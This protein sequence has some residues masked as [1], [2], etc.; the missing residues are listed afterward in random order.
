M[1]NPD[2]IFS[3]V[4][5]VDFASYI[6]GPAATTILSDFGATVIKVE[7]PGTG[8]PYRNLY[9]LAPNPVCDTNYPWQLTNRNKQSLA[10]DLKSPAAKDIVEKLVKWADVVVVN[11]PLSVRDKLGISYEALAPLND[12]LIY[13]DITGYGLKGPEANRPGFDV[14]TYWARSGLMEVTRDGDSPPAVPIPGIG[15]HATASTLFSAIVT[16]LYHREKTGKGSRVSTS[17]IAEGAWASALWTEGALNGAKFYGAHTRNA[18]LNALFNPYR[19][20]DNR[21]LLLMLLQANKEF[22]GL[23]KA[24][25]LPSLL[26]DPRFADSEGRT[27]HATELVG[28]LDKA[29]AGHSLEYWKKT[30]DEARVIYGVVQVADEVVKDEQMYANE[31]FVPLGEAGEK[32]TYTV[33]SPMQISGVDKVKPR[34]APDLGEHSRDVLATLGYDANEIERLINDKVVAQLDQAAQSK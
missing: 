32:T 21:W 30:F 2:S 25:D 23:C 26:E 18:P 29:F 14:T 12:R 4:K 1:Q 8:D 11:F 7:P 34:R 19:T 16:G 33:N 27:K 28:I 24:M 15:D 17:L 20:A 13:A 9:K 10:L 3:E 22:P 31:V 5:V 6:A